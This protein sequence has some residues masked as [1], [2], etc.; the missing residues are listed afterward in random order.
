MCWLFILG[1]FP[2]VAT[3]HLLNKHALLIVLS[4][5]KVALNF[6]PVACIDVYAA[7]HACA[8]VFRLYDVNSVHPQKHAARLG[9]MVRT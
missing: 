9:Y 6:Y 5:I 1:I 8:A 2:G 3:L 7:V 4:Y